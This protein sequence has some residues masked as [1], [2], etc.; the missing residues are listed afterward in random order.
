MVFTRRSRRWGRRMLRA[1]FKGAKYALRGANKANAA[2]A[3]AA[4]ALRNVRYIKGLVN[5][6][7]FHQ[8]NTVSATAITSTGLIFPITSI[9]Q[10]DGAGQRTGNS[11]LLR[12][13]MMR[14]RLTRN[15]SSVT[16]VVRFMI[17]QDKQQISDTSPAISDVLQSVSVDSPLN[18]S[19]LGRFKVLYNR[20]I[21]LDANK[22]MWH[23]ETYRKL[24]TH[25]RYNG[26]AGTDIQRGGLYCL[27][28]SDQPTNSPLLDFY[29]RTGYHDN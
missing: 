5:S 24:Y 25:I 16:T 6:E 29:L 9:G 10:G 3:A 14:A 15:A 11:I 2:Y 22:P 18:T 26:N 13:F 4:L 21:L 28:I 8:D 20:T 7:T 27:F 23:K 17:I 12:N 1:P 19:S